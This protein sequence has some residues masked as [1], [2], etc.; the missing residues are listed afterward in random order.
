MPAESI[1]PPPPPPPSADAE[2]GTGVYQDPKATYQFTEKDGTWCARWGQAVQQ[3]WTARV[4]LC[5]LASDQ[6]AQLTLGGSD[7]G[8]G[9][10]TA[11]F[12]R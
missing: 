7:G 5:P 12:R 9:L 4:T 10:Q 2:K 8:L 1:D 11:T 3:F 6:M